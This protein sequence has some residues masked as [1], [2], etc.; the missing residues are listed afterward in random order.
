M[1]PSPSEESAD[2]DFEVLPTDSEP[3]TP[4]IGYTSI[5]AAISPLNAQRQKTKP[6]KQSPFKTLLN[7]CSTSCCLSWMSIAFKAKPKRETYENS[8]YDRFEP[9]ND[10]E[11]KI[12]KKMTN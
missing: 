7:T 8:V 10:L 1:M 6:L 11:I 3:A 9:T 4:T 5:T 2:S 12:L